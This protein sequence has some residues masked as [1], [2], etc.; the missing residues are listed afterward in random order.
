MFL[1]YSFRYL[2][3]VFRFPTYWSLFFFSPWEEGQLGVPKGNWD[4]YR[5]SYGRLSVI[6][7]EGMGFG[8]F[9]LFFIF[10]ICIR[11]RTVRTPLPR[12][13]EDWLYF[14]LLWMPLIRTS[15]EVEFV[16]RK[17]T[18]ARHFTKSV[19]TSGS[20]SLFDH[21]HEFLRLTA[22]KPVPNLSILTGQW[23]TTS[24]WRGSCCPL[25]GSKRGYLIPEV[26]RL[27]RWSVQIASITVHRSSGV[28]FGSNGS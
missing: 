5:V 20:D 4:A 21:S 24:S 8:D 11:Q 16:R 18:S 27:V 28:Y 14:I 13:F 23:C 1:V 2:A 7:R 15:K 26:W 9:H 17:K 3:T 19:R 10:S 6:F 25:T 12:K 22:E